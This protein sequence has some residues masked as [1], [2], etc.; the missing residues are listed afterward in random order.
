MAGQTSAKSNNSNKNLL[1]DYIKTFTRKGKL[2]KSKV[3][4]NSM[5]VQM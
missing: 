1:R 2:N 3:K 4:T 5:L